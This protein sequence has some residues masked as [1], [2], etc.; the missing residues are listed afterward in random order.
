LRIPACGRRGQG[1]LVPS[2]STTFVLYFISARHPAS[3]SISESR[4]WRRFGSCNSL[5]ACSASLGHH[6]AVLI[7]AIR[8]FMA[9]DAA[10]DDSFAL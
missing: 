8:H 6:S 2:R 9:D 3:E 7:A 1:D 10:S 5:C 4:R